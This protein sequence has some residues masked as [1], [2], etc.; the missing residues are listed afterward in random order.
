MQIDFK[1]INA[2][3]SAAWSG[4]VDKLRAMVDAHGVM[5]LDEVDYDYST[6]LMSAI[7]GGHKNAVEFL[8]SVGADVDFKNINGKDVYDVAR[9]QIEFLV[10]RVPPEVPGDVAMASRDKMRVVE[11]CVALMKSAPPYPKRRAAYQES[12]I[13]KSGVTQRELP[14][15]RPPLFRPR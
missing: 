7:D 1:I 8:I 13:K 4:D 12:L 2:F 3:T 14:Q 6:A 11:A 10:H 9:D 5:I 15:I